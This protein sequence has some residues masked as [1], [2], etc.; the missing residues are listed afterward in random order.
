M[1]IILAT[2]TLLLALTTAL[3]PT[4]LH[5]R[6]TQFAP[7]PADLFT[8]PSASWPPGPGNLLTPQL[9][10]AELQQIMSEISPVRI[11]A[12]IEKLVSFGTRN[13][14]SNQTDPNRGIG[15]ARDW[16]AGQMRGFAETSGGRMSVSVEG[17]VQGVEAR[18]PFPVRI[19]NIVA[20]LRGESD[21]GRVYVISGHYDSRVTD[22]NNYMSDAPGADDDGSGVA[23]SME[24]ARIMA[25][26]RPAAT[27]VFM[28]VAGEE[29]N[30]YGSNFQAQ[31]YKNASVNVEGMFT[32]DIIGASTGDDGTKDPNTIRLFAQGAP[33][34][35]SR[36]MTSTRASIGGD[37]DSPA[38]ELA[39]FV[40]G[41]AINQYTAMD[42]AV[43]YRADR[44]LRGGDHLSFLKAG[45]PAARFTEPI[46]NFAH[47]HQDVRVENGTQYGDLAAFCDY[48][49]IQRAG[50]VN[51]AAMW[52]LAQAP[53]TPRNVTI[54]VSVLTNK[55]SFKWL[56]SNESGLA[57]YELVW[58]PTDAPFW[59]HVIAV[60]NVDAYTVNLS[61]DNVNF[62]IRAVG[63]NGYRSPAAF[64]F[65]G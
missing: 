38:R 25:T 2:T 5:H 48:D 47:Q 20:T 56:S 53:G 40:V 62:G 12:I 55:S 43:I 9:P 49:Y 63:T 61:K 44:Y 8:C 22:V 41:V 39:R 27:I 17:Y 58:R 32:N 24:L 13:T 34:T 59:T 64:P 10:D 52:S 51:A 50:K 29:Q 30:L 33:T 3:P 28:A 15:A 31:K 7:S 23:V 42:V 45:Y 37:S 57:G 54:D 16:I 11:Q 65:P 36:A 46:E 26:R 35:E 60:G 18:V 19:S 1:L 14:F 4:C 21:Q 6:S